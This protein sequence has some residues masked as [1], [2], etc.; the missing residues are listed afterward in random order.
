M[1]A[2]ESVIPFSLQFISAFLLFVLNDS[3]SLFLILHDC[4]LS[5][6]GLLAFCF[7]NLKGDLSFVGRSGTAMDVRY[8][9][10]DFGEM[11]EEMT[12]HVVAFFSQNSKSVPVAKGIYIV[13]NSCFMYIAPLI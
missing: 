2:S 1:T 4:C 9:A 8:T 11:P 12:K 3:V 13:H 7:S 6:H 10:H 5:N